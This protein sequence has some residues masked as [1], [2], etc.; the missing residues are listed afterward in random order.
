MRLGKCSCAKVSALTLL[1]LLLVSS[2][3]TSTSLPLRRAWTPGTTAPHPT[4][5]PMLHM[6]LSLAEW[7]RDSIRGRTRAGVNRA[8]AEGRTGGR[9]QS[10]GTVVR[11]GGVR[12]GLRGEQAHR[13]G[14]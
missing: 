2:R 6:L 12:Q 9:P 10:V 11:E 14:G 7:E 4:S 1:P 5:K 13:A 3:H 8:A